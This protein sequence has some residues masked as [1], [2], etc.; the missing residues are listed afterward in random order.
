M[1]RKII[2]SIKGAI[3]LHNQFGVSYSQILKSFFTKD[4]TVT[5]RI[6]NLIFTKNVRRALYIARSLINIEKHGW[7]ITGTTDD[8]VIFENKSIK[9][10]SRID[11][12][13]P[14]SSV[15]HEIF[16]KEEYKANVKD[17]VVI[18]V[19]A[20]CGESAIYF[21]LQGAMKV[22]ALEPDRENYKIA[23]RNI[24]ENG[25]EDKI[26]LLN[27]A[28]APKEGT[29]SFYKYVHSSIANSTDPDNMDKLN[30]KIVIE[31][32][33]AITL[34]QL[35][36]DEK[37]GLLKLDCEGCEYSVLNSFS[38]YDKIE[39]IILEY[40]NGLQNLPD[41]L[42]ANGFDFTIEENRIRKWMGILR[43]TKRVR[44]V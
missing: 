1:I 22:I 19:G 21:A 43:A 7:K 41:L 30:D 20:Y 32:V 44:G 24:R 27:K 37:I 34:D 31:Q 18:D 38:G 5:L 15:I 16:I 8:L 29:I 10:Y 3:L 36:G 12:D 33:E 39:N 40:H 25:L 13:I 14:Y 2:A 17:K 42:K 28:L 35:I 9:L 23:L 26:V 4:K 6:G 11:D